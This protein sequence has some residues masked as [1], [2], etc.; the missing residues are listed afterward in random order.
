MSVKKT[1]SEVY[2]FFQKAKQDGIFQKCICVWIWW[3]TF[4]MLGG[5][6]PIRFILKIYV[7]I[8]YIT[9]KSECFHVSLY[10][11]LLLQEIENFIWSK[12]GLDHL[13]LLSCKDT[14][15]ST[16]WIVLFGKNYSVSM[17]FF[18]FFKSLCFVSEQMLCSQ[19]IFLNI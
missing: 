14:K 16:T 8:S 19:V 1:L 3:I 10:R 9:S 13:V 17:S 7:L 11:A 4:S 12:N 5:Q 2:S 6:L 15:F 18:P